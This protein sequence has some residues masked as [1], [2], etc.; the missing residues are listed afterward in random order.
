MTK[1]VDTIQNIEKYFECLVSNGYSFVG[2]YYST[3]TRMPQKVLTPA[4]AQAISQAGLRI[5]S[6]FEDLPTSAGYFTA[7]RGVGDATGARNQA[8]GVGQPGGTP[9]YFTVDYNAEPADLA[10]I[11][12]Y[13]TA[14]RVTL[15]G[16]GD[17]APYLLGVYGSGLVCSYLLEAGLIEYTWLSQSSGF[18]GTR[19]FRQGGTWNILQLLPQA[20]PEPCGS[21]DYDPNVSNGKEGSWS[22]SH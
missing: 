18:Y 6:V 10:A 5:V 8:L 16:A 9:I 4:E 14:V 20:A 12:A 17:A 1:G 11:T 22:L 21:F 15:K 7:S 13:I 2:R 3:T 19:E